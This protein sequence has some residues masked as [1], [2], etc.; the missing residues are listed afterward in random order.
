[1]QV[2]SALLAFFFVS[3]IIQCFDAPYSDFICPNLNT[4][5]GHSSQI[6]AISYLQDST[7]F[8]STD[9]SNRL[10]IRDVRD[11]QVVR[12]QDTPLTDQNGIIS[13]SSN[14]NGQVVAIT[15]TEIA[16]FN[17]YK[18]DA[19]H[20]IYLSCLEYLNIPN[21]SFL[22]IGY[23]NGYIQQLDISNITASG[24]QNT[25]SNSKNT[26]VSTYLSSNNSI[27]NSYYDSQQNIISTV[28]TLNYDATSQSG[29]LFY[30]KHN[31]Q[32]N[33]SSQAIIQ[34]NYSIQ[35]QNFILDT[36]QIFSIMQNNYQFYTALAKNKCPK[37]QTSKSQI[38]IN[39]FSYQFY[40]GQKT[41][42]GKF[43]LEQFN[44]TINN[45]FQTNI[46][47]QNNQKYS[48]LFFSAQPF[49]FSS[50]CIVNSS[51]NQTDGIS[52]QSTSHVHALIINLSTN[53]V[54]YQTQF[55]ILQQDRNTIQLLNFRVDT[56]QN[57]FIITGNYIYIL[58]PY[59]DLNNQTQ[60]FKQSYKLSDIQSMIKKFTNKSTLNIS[61][62]TS[63]NLIPSTNQFVL[64]FYCNTSSII[65][66]LST[67]FFMYN[68]SSQTGFQIEVKKVFIPK[69]QNYVENNLP[70]IFQL[71]YMNDINLIVCYLGVEIR[72]LNL[73]S[74]DYNI[75]YLTNFIDDYVVL[76]SSIIFTNN[77]N[78]QII[79]LQ[80]NFEIQII[81]MNS[82]LNNQCSYQYCNYQV[83]L[84]Q[85][86]ESD[87]SHIFST[88]SILQRSELLLISNYKLAEL[89]NLFSQIN[90]IFII[91]IQFNTDFECKSC[92][93]YFVIDDVNIYLDKQIFEF[94][95]LL[96][97]FQNKKNS[98]QIS[99][100]LII[101]PEGQQLQSQL[102]LQNVLVQ[103]QNFTNTTALIEVIQNDYLIVLTNLTFQ[104]NKFENTNF[105]YSTNKINLII[106]NSTFQNNLLLNNNSS[107][108]I[109]QY[110]IMAQN[111]TLSNATFSQ[112][113]IQDLT[114]FGLNSQSIQTNWNITQTN[115]VNNTFLIN[116][117]QIQALLI[118]CQ[119]IYQSLGVDQQFYL[120]SSIF[121]N[122]KFYSC[123]YTEFQLNQCEVVNTYDNIASQQM[124]QLYLIALDQIQQISLSLV[125]DIDNQISFLLLISPAQL[126]I[127]KYSCY[128]NIMNMFIFDQA[129]INIQQFEQLNFTL[130]DSNFENKNILNNYAIQIYSNLNTDYQQN[131]QQLISFNNINFN[132]I[133]I[134]TASQHQ[135]SSAIYIF[136][137]QQLNLKF[138]KLV[139]S[140]ITYET[141]Q[142]VIQRQSSC[143][144]IYT[145]LSDLDLQNSQ[146]LNLKT[147]SQQAVVFGNLNKI[148]ID[149]CN[150]QN[151][152]F[153][154]S[155]FQGGFIQFETDNLSVIQSN[156]TKGQASL[157]GA[158]QIK[159]RVQS[160]NY[161]F[162]KC[163]FD[164]LFSQSDGGAIYIGETL[165]YTQ[166]SVNSC[167][168]QNI[169][170]NRGGA[171]FIQYILYQNQQ[172]INYQSYPQIY[173]KNCSSYN[174][175]SQEGGLIFAQNSN[176][177]ID[178]FSSSLYNIAQLLDYSNM[179]SYYVSNFGKISEF[180]SIYSSFLVITQMNI[181]ENQIISNI[182]GNSN[183]QITFLSGQYKS[184]ILI[185]QSN[186]DNCLLSQTSFI[187]IGQSELSFISSNLTNIQAINR[188]N[189]QL[190]TNIQQDQN[191][192]FSILTLIQS[193]IYLENSTF[194]NISCLN[195][196]CNG[197][198]VLLIN[199]GGKIN[200]CKFTFNQ[201][202]G[203][204]GAINI[205]NINQQLEIINS[206]FQ[207]NV[208]LN[209]LGG[210]LAFISN[211]D[212]N[213]INFL[214]NI[215][216]NNTALQGGGLYFEFQFSSN[217]KKIL[218]SILQTS[219][220]YN[221][222]MTAGGGIYYQG[223]KPFFDSKTIIT[224]NYAKSSFG[225]NMFSIPKQ[226][227]LSNEDHT[228]KYSTYYDSSGEVIY[229]INHQVSGKALPSLTFL[230]IDEE[231]NIIDSSY[232]TIAQS[233][234]YDLTLSI[235]KAEGFSSS[236]FAIT[237]F[238]QEF[239]FVGYYNVSN[240]A[241]T[242]IPGKS[243]FLAITIDLLRQKKNYRVLLE[244]NLRPCIRGEIYSLYEDL[245]QNPP[246]KL[247]S[248]SQCQYGM[249]SLA[250][251]NLNDTSIGCKE[252]S[253]HATC[254]GGYIIDVKKGY[255]RLND[256]TDEII[257]CVNA[258]QNCI[259]GQANYTCSQGHIGPL[260]ESCDLKNNYSNIGNFECG[261]CGNKI[262]NSLKIV[263][264]M[265]FY[266]FSAKIS[267]DGIIKRLFDIL[268]KSGI[269]KSEQQKN[270][271]ETSVLLKLVLNYFQIIM[272]ISTLQI[273][274]PSFFNDTVNNISNPT[275][276]LL[277]S[278]ECFFYQ[279][280]QKIGINVIYIQIIVSVILPIVCFLVFFFTGFIQYK[281]NPLKK[282]MYLYTS[283]LYC[284]L[285]F[286]PS[287]FKNAI[288]IINCR[289]IGQIKYIQYNSLYQCFTNEYYKW[290]LAL[291]L[292]IVLTFSIII[293]LFI[294]LMIKQSQKSKRK[295]NTKKYIL[296]T[297]EYK[298][299]FWYW[300]F[301]KMYMKLFIMCCLVFYQYDIPNKI[302]CIFFILCFYGILLLYI[303]PYKTKIYQKL[304]LSQTIIM[305]FS[306][307]FG[308]VA[309]QNQ[310][311]LFWWLFSIIF[312]A[313]INLLYILWCFRLI[314]KAY[315]YQQ[316]SNIEKIMIYLVK[317]ACCKKYFFSKK[318]KIIYLQ[319]R[320]V[321]SFKQ[322]MNEKKMINKWTGK[323]KVDRLQAASV[324]LGEEFIKNQQSITNIL[325]SRAQIQQNIQMQ[326]N[327]LN[328]VQNKQLNENF[329][330]QT[331]ID[332]IINQQIK[333]FQQR[334]SYDFKQIQSNLSNKIDNQNESL[335]PQIQLEC[336]NFNYQF[337]SNLSPTKINSC[338]KVQSSI[339]DDYKIDE[340]A[341]PDFDINKF[342]IKQ[343]QF[344]TFQNLN[345]KQQKKFLISDSQQTN[346]D[347]LK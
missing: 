251:P 103:K 232:I 211:Q 346:Q 73:S 199:S 255:W 132:N 9:K 333:S 191:S 239:E 28:S 280:H 179:I 322:V 259:G 4:I 117:W 303:S 313:I 113:V 174:L 270:I 100:S 158:L 295:Q 140:Q 25:I 155:I 44:I 215:F 327:P 200:N 120:T 248:C 146:F 245:T 76:G 151:N 212:Q 93:Q 285:Y 325:K 17:S 198:S 6:T 324:L 261:A 63:L 273:N 184:S 217:K 154:S 106:E 115:L 97:F 304:D 66:S 334:K 240:L 36:D 292:P 86:K 221:K 105:I 84:N 138:S 347:S 208:A 227:K 79:K 109:S 238:Q 214:N 203:N 168:F 47:T 20:I 193:T 269:K 336:S 326:E 11:G 163:Q 307:Y 24:S 236:P 311:S 41:I 108:S 181:N 228:F 216:K 247:Y 278:F 10:F 16:I 160:A 98:N 99:N 218:A 31:F 35:I 43:N 46:Y 13:L 153:Q 96:L 225:K 145:P 92:N 224:S 257:Q 338:D 124:I 45:F 288:S 141:P 277:F 137:F 110:F 276:F 133:I 265:L 131:T 139:F 249:Y 50:Y 104:E 230:L 197:G 70:N 294:F 340:E 83:N 341:Q 176:I 331:Q 81:D 194:T 87:L 344:K 271:S 196:F 244:I 293:P 149:S 310:M 52:L 148:T 250:Y 173:F 42:Y 12:Y 72:I 69:Q 34:A 88:D 48:L 21:S 119:P 54:Y 222:A 329:I 343:T 91:N 318:K 284:F 147:F 121:Q 266:I 142:I 167:I 135:Q 53:I 95:D 302:L 180:I 5:Q 263:G 317:F 107:I 332:Q 260:C 345:Q 321:R 77:Q 210:G 289:K 315:L 130:S 172:M 309:Y 207:N 305:T 254:P 94:L 272:V 319:K 275:T 282:A 213:Q 187:N 67:S 27:D 314:T 298:D 183:L 33:N 57:F 195:Q 165:N 82:C 38:L 190:Q 126:D 241:V 169:V 192:Q 242:G 330:S 75:Q 219:I 258:P 308:F 256:Q 253:T 316:Q 116:L 283:F 229:R 32:T 234:N 286:Q 19:L 143:L 337:Q 188:V 80:P 170:S 291:V 3:K 74:V 209:G 78:H 56:Q 205:L 342:N 287:I 61:Q 335:E 185:Q 152:N 111:V 186:F 7:I 226:I 62:F 134:R 233:L 125:Q 89:A 40:N 297:S 23:T 68:Q 279:L 267:V 150:F 22:L 136:S 246:E 306:I 252:C 118:D 112:N 268:D 127:K 129:C 320:W 26:Y 37:N 299:K 1:M 312:I 59:L 128:N 15:K 296:M 262:I 243:I 102:N 264:L 301:I 206:Q 65:N 202:F 39:S 171:I 237:S 178:Q 223:Q 164:Q 8:L 290:S 161:S 166:I 339:F 114:L 29:Y 274:I 201:C 2:I 204:G 144:L 123:Y 235:N 175:F 51:Q 101:V 182:R 64:Q 90:I 162:Y 323:L 58:K 49:N 122:T 55:K 60:I 300:E 220:Q 159:P 30:Q 281:N 328:S 177:T 156:F 71:Q 18:Y 85:E 231:G 189:R 14:R 157:G